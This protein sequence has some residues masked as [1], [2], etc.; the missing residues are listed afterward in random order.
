[1]SE[2]LN[3]DLTLL[4]E[5]ARPAATAR[6]Q[7]GRNSEEA[8]AALVSHH[9]NLVYSVALRQV[10][11]PHLAEEITQAVFIILARKATALSPKTI[12][13]GWLCRTARYASANALTIQRRRQR[14]EQEAHMQS[15]LNEAANEPAETWNQIAPLLDGAMEKLG[16]KDHD[17][18]VLR[19]FEGRNFKEVG[20][21]LGASE[22]AAKMRVNRALEKLR[23]FFTKRGVGSTT[24]IIA[25]TMAANSVQAAPVALAK[26]VTVVAIAKGAA[27]TGSTL[28]LIKGALKI[29]AWTKAKTAVAVGVGVLLAAGTTTLTIKE[30]KEHKT[31]SV[32]FK[33]VL[34]VVQDEDG[35][36]VE[37]ATILPDGFRVKGIH[38]AD[39]YG[40]NKKL[41]G[42]PEK[43]VTD[44]DGKAY[45]KYPVE[46]IPEEK[47]FTGKLIFSVSH[48]EF[49]TVRPQ[50]YSVDSPEQPIQLTHG[51]HLEV[52]GYVG[53]DHQAVT[54][55]VPNLNEEIIHKEDWQ[56]M[57]NGVYAFHK[58]SPGGH[59]IQLMGRLPSGE[60]VYSESFA[61]TT[62][63][64]K[65]Y[66]FALKMKLGIRLEGRLDDKVPRP[67]K[68]GRV[69]ISVRPNEFPAWNNYAAV[70]DI[71]K[72]Y[73]NFY[74]WK[75][76]RPITEDGTFVFESIPP[77]GLDVIVHGDGFVSQSG[78]DFSQRINSKLVKVPGF[79]LPQPFS[80][81]APTTKIEVV[82]EP[83]ATLEL[84]A[85]TKWGKPVAGA[86]VYLNPNVVRMNGIFGNMRQSNE[87][88]FR[89]LAP[90]PDVPYSA[91]TDKNGVAVIRNVPAT[92]RGMEVY[93]P[94]FQ[95]P[96]QEPKGWR[97]R[98]IRMTFSPGATNQ[99]ELTL[100]PKGKDFIGNN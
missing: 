15:I 51:I 18:V 50:E 56:K 78:G 26:S 92:T 5:Y 81:V 47:E 100:E 55:L 41:F 88:P 23:I 39:A 29:M 82:T 65:E 67:V 4:R 2:M 45:V 7:G 95:V 12:L 64:G 58:L 60:I 27:A 6:E 54:E 68:N 25:G 11:D 28:T 69:L 53:S 97:D 70:D 35:K 83:T 38:G 19:F 33:K 21:A 73:P 3:D 61:F 59:L 90:L 20:A 80:L 75:S 40:W 62:E 24:A 44:R 1:M 84:T 72:K 74:P 37:G 43:A 16:K 96:L 91:T 93:H 86:T 48:P 36:P 85:K 49:S 77:G 30:I 94:Q 8:F 89:T 9:V 76:Y 52:A 34:V 13:P 42:P 31:Y 17:A 46:G 32:E 14:R 10:R 99:F 79:A 66:N 71:L 63:K 57:E 87:E 98:H 22:D